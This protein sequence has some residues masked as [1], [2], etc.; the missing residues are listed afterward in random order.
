MGHSAGAYNAGMLALDRRYLHRA[1]IAARGIAGFIGLAGPYDFL[2]LRSSVTRGVFGYPD[3]P[4]TTQPIEF[5]GSDAPPSLLIT[6]DADTT[7]DP[8]NS[9]R[10]AARLRASG[11]DVDHR[12]YSG[13]GHRALVDAL[14]ERP[15][16]VRRERGETV[17]RRAR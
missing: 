2:P 12:I 13:V 17:D 8:G 4:R 16:L 15:R 5:A 1:G 3:T 14:P 9:E 10:L 7:V 11:N 6:G